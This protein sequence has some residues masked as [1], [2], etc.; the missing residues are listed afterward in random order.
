VRR[1]LRNTIIPLA[2]RLAPIQRRAVRRMSHIHVAYPSSP[3]TQRSR[4]RG[5]VRPGERAPDL[6]MTGHGGE[7]RLYE[8]L[9]HGRPVLVISAQAPARTCRRG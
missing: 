9:R 2:G 6:D 4:S 7:T 8:V 5:G 3:L 1:A